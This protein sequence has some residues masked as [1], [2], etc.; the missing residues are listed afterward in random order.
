MAIRDTLSAKLA[1]SRSSIRNFIL[2]EKSKFKTT[3]R[4]FDTRLPGNSNQG[5]LFGTAL[6]DEDKAALLEYMKML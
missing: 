1:G 4:I 3:G 5:H 6:S 2:G